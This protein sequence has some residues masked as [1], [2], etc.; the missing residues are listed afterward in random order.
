MSRNLCSNSSVPPLFPLLNQPS[1]NMAAAGAGAPAFVAPV[2]IWN[3]NPLTGNFNP[4]TVAGQK[5]SLEKTKGLATAGKLPLSNASAA[6]IMEFLKMKE[7]IMGTVVTGVPTVYT[8]GIGSS[9]MNLIHQSP[10]IPLEIFQ[11]GA[12]ARFGTA[13]ADG[14]TIPAH[15]WISVALDPANNNADEAKF[16]T[17]VYVN[18]VVEI[19]KNFLTPNGWYDLML[20]QHKF[21]FTYITGMKSYDGPTMLKVLLEEIDPTVSV[22][23]KP[24]RQAIEGAKLQ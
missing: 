4:G 5:I 12:H 16:Y 17:R 18:V 10:S 3:K 11:R 14:D 21:A 13:F 2:V 23:V 7:H 20:Q 9:P 1:I 24:H 6:K 22:N 19:V 15:P 8:A